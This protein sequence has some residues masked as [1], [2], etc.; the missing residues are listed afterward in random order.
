MAYWLTAIAMLVLGFLTGYS[1]GPFLLLIGVAML[2]LGPFRRRPLV[3][4]PPMAG[5]FAFIVGFLAVAPFWCGANAVEPG[6]SSTTVC[7]SLIGITYTGTGSYNPS[8][9]PG[10]YAGLAF[11]AIAVSLAAGIMWWRHRQSDA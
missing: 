1:V 6:G 5:V 11:A 4:W 10:V 9:L 3:F 8:L 7:S 2:I